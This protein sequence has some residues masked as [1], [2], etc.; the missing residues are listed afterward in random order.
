MRQPLI[1]LA[2]DGVVGAY[3]R[4]LAAALGED[5]RVEVPEGEGAFEPQRLAALVPRADFI[6]AR[7]LSAPVAAAARRCR[8][9]QSWI[10]GVD[11][12][13]MAAMR[14]AGLRLAAAHEN[15]TAVAEQALGLVLALGRH[16]ARGD[17]HL[18]RGRWTVGFSAGSPPHPGVSGRTVTVVGYG[19][20][21]RAF[22]R[23]ASGLGFR[24]IGVRRHPERARPPGD[25]AAE[26][27]G[28]DRLDRALR[29]ADYVLL[30]LPKTR[31]T[32]GL[33]GANRLAAM[34]P[35]A[36]LVQVGR[37]ETVDERALFEAC[38]DRRIAGAGI[39]VWWSYPEPAAYSPDTVCFP[40]RFPFHELDNVVLTP[41]SSGW[42]EEAREAQVAFVVENVRRV[43]R[44]AAPEGLVDLEI[45]Y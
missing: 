12:F 9:V 35:E 14:A 1:V 25:P 34:R 37:S 31:E 10:A 45:G 18:R 32:V 15:A 11:R 30:A 20:I 3:A 22:A 6:V 41:H 43:A 23:L 13:D 16:L 19:S 26:V 44:G 5:F 36:W 2:A 33:I 7:E 39:D 42:T 29:E 21:G 8:L 28:V 4:R 27:V 24:L 17:R 38:R 40:S